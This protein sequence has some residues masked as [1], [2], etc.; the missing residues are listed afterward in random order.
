MYIVTFTA[1]VKKKFSDL[2]LFWAGNAT[3]IANF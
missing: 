2:P 1:P 3:D